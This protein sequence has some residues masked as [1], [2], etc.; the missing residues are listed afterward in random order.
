MN[1]YTRVYLSK[2]AEELSM[3]PIEY[4]PDSK[5]ITKPITVKSPNGPV[6]FDPYTK[7]K[8]QSWFKNSI[9][10]GAVNSSHN[11]IV[12][13]GIHMAKAYGNQLYPELAKAEAYNKE[14]GLRSGPTAGNIEKKVP[15]SWN[16]SANILSTGKS[17]NVGPNY[18]NGK[19]MMNTK[20]LDQSIL[21]QALH[22]GTHNDPY[23]IT[24]DNTLK[25]EGFHALYDTPSWKEESQSF[26]TNLNS[27]KNKEQ[28]PFSVTGS[29]L[30]NPTT[31]IPHDIMPE[32]QKD[33][34]SQIQQNQFQQTGSRFDDKQWEDSINNIFPEGQQ[35]SN[36]NFEQSIS[37]F[38]PDSRRMFREM[39][40]VRETNPDQYN[41]IKNWQIKRMP[42]ITQN[43]P[44]TIGSRNVS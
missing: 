3:P 37:Q 4:A 5:P 40:N 35:V 14:H 23:N 24:E 32:E 26:L 33:Y 8:N 34:L 6:T 10:T 12:Q 31:D 29:T 39:R 19:I 21:N 11:G 13:P 25:H 22:D 2:L 17:N 36:Q 16:D 20:P 30:K 43:S 15:V 41:V 7:Y 1:Q 28:F 9:V 44:M 18:W 27:V 38:P 42:G